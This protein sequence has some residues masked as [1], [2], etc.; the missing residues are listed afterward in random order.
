MRR[1]IAAIAFAVSAGVVVPLHAGAVSGVVRSVTKAGGVAALAVVYAEPIDSAAPRAPR[2]ATLTQKNKTFQP[3]V[4]AVPI[5][6]T[7]DPTGTAST[8]G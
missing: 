8:R 4:L 7:V 2:R 5:G 1:S 6:S 3:R